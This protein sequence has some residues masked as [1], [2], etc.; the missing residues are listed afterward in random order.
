MQAIPSPLPIAPIPSLVD[1]FTLTGAERT[2]L[3]SEAISAL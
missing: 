3:S 1:A 2:P